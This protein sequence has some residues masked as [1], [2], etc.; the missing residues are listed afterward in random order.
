MS[1]LI[2][3]KPDSTPEQRIEWWHEYEQD[4]AAHIRELNNAV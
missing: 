2:E 3:L 1:V 4:K